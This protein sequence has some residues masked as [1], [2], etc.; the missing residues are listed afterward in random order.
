MRIHNDDP[1]LINK[2]IEEA[3]KDIEDISLK[4]ALESM[5]YKAYEIHAAAKKH[6]INLVLFLD[7][8][9][10]NGKITFIT[11]ATGKTNSDNIKASLFPIVSSEFMDIPQMFHE[12]VI[13][14][15][16][17]IK[18]VCSARKFE[19]TSNKTKH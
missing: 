6:N 5:L 8:K 19:D 16:T 10:N 13:E 11:G 12:E 3:V 17:S 15:I 18:E 9:V 1:K 2:L 4:G 7:P 14:F